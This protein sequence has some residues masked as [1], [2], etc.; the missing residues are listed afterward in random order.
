M[1]INKLALVTCFVLVS[2]FKGYGQSKLKFGLTGGFHA[3]TFMYSGGTNPGGKQL[4][5]IVTESDPKSWFSGGI[6]LNYSITERLSAQLEAVYLP[7]NIRAEWRATYNG[8][9]TERP[10][11][12]F[13]KYDNTINNFA[14]PILIKY[15]IG[16][17]LFVSPYA[18]MTFLLP[19]SGG[20]KSQI[21]YEYP[22]NVYEGDNTPAT[23]YLDRVG[24]ASLNMGLT[25][26]ANLGINLNSGGKIALDFRYLHGITEAYPK[27]EY[28]TQNGLNTNF[29]G[30]TLG[31]MAIFDLE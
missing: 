14:V 17:K 3:S 7:Q 10:Y 22:N 27:A 13:A 6:V 2:I 26:G 18:G 25:A 1:K 30:I 12:Q 5:P 23:Y 4:W 16:K 28:H 21:Q 15:E 29:K 9:A 24:Y 8:S 20:W 31:V 11:K 19:M